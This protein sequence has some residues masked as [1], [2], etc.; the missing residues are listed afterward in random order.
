MENALIKGKKRIKKAFVGRTPYKALHSK[1][2]NL[3]ISGKHFLLAIL[4]QQQKPANRG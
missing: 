3:F 1:Q 2:S 4:F